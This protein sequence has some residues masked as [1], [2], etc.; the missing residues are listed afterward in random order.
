MAAARRYSRKK[1][2]RT[3][4]FLAGKWKFECGRE[5]QGMRCA[6]ERRAAPPPLHRAPSLPE[7]GFSLHSAAGL[8]QRWLRPLCVHV[9]P[10]PMTL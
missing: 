10:A 9:S 5:G 4:S 2:R 6:G 3:S 7:A 8:L 1:L